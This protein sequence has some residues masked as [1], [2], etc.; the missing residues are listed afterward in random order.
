MPVGRR[1]QMAAGHG[2]EIGQIQDHAV[3][4]EGRDAEVILKVDGIL[5]LI[6][7]QDIEQEGCDEEP[8]GLLLGKEGDESHG[9][10]HLQN[11]DGL[12]PRALL[13]EEGI[14]HLSVGGENI[15]KQVA[16]ILQGGEDSAVRIY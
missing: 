16:G 13:R 5:V 8:A 6:G 11:I 7:G 12:G 10:E 9:Q 2:L 4:E 14:H 1:Q 15:R 3:E